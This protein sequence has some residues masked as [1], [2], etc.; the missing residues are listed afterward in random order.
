MKC[1]VAAA[2]LLLALG[3]SPADGIGSLRHLYIRGSALEPEADA[4]VNQ[5]GSVDEPVGQG[6]IPA[7]FRNNDIAGEAK[8]KAATWKKNPAGA[9]AY[10]CA[11]IW[12]SIVAL[13][14]AML[15]FAEEGFNMN[16]TKTQIVETVLVYIWLIGGLYLF[17]NVLLFQSP[18]FGGEIRSLSLEEAVYLFAQIVTTVGYGDITPAKPRGQVFVGIFV[19]LSFLLVAGLMSQLA[20]IVLE[21]ISEKMALESEEVDVEVMLSARTKEIKRTD[22]MWTAAT[23]LMHT[24]AVFSMF[25]VIGVIFFSQYPGENKTV[26]QAIYMS[27]IT[28]S[29]VGFGAFTPVTHVGMVFG[30]FWMLFGVTSLGA[31]ISSMAAFVAAMKQIE[32]DRIK[33]EAAE[34]EKAAQL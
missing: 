28:L 20:T 11:I 24:S 25:L 14:P 10:V 18:H 3:A 8:K 27:F 12:V 9:G 34:A 33:S 5:T 32:K 30:A 13:M 16:F 31:V 19:V 7:P 2:A 15:H 1:R 21:R 4:L 29:S 26:F 22:I 23:P 17:T 6:G